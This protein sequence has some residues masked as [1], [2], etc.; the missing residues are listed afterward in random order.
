MVEH[1][2]VFNDKVGEEHK[3]RDEKPEKF[4]GTPS[5]VFKSRYVNEK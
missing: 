3:I 1:P 5:F 4:M 2:I